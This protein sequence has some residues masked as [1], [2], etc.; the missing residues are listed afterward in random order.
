MGAG[1]ALSLGSFAALIPV[2]LAV[3]ALT[4]RTLGEEG[5]LIESLPGYPE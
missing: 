4:G 3:I 2:G 5:V 1:C